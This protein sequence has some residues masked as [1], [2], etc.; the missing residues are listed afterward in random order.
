MVEV[1]RRL[2]KI[3]VWGKVNES[4]CNGNIYGK[5]ADKMHLDLHSRPRRAVSLPLPRTPAACLSHSHGE[6]ITTCPWDRC[7]RLLYIYTCVYEWLT[8]GLCCSAQLS[9]DSVNQLSESWKADTLPRQ[10]LTAGIAAEK[11]VCRQLYF[12]TTHF[13]MILRLLPSPP[14]PK[15]IMKPVQFVLTFA[16]HHRHVTSSQHFELSVI[17]FSPKIQAKF[18]RNILMW[19]ACILVYFQTKAPRDR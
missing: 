15:Y 12:I 13:I 10:T 3:S 1:S 6:I 18:R 2:I 16:C 11:W 14:S 4:S 19:Q 8:A 7:A 9:C 5:F 17:R